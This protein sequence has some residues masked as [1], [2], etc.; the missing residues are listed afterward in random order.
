ML[1]NNYFRD[2]AKPLE[3]LKKKKLVPH[4]KQFVSQVCMI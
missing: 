4:V 2:S 3:K 1:K